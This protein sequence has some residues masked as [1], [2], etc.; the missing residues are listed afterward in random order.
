VI[1]DL[2][3]IASLT[4]ETTTGILKQALHNA[5][6]LDEVKLRISGLSPED[7]HQL[8]DE[9]MAL[10]AVAEA[11]AKQ[12][13]A[14][15][16]LPIVFKIGRGSLKNKIIIIPLVLILNFLL[17][18]ALSP[19]LV[20]GGI[21]LAYEGFE[22]I[23]D[24]FKPHTIASAEATMAQLGT[25]HMEA[26]KVA[27]AIKTDFILSFEIIVITLAL[28]EKTNFITQLMVLIVIAILST[29]FVYGIVALIIKLDDIGF[30]LQTKKDPLMPQ[31]G[32]C[33]VACMP[34]LIQIISI[35]GTVAM[36]LV[37]GGIINHETHLLH[38]AHAWISAIPLAS[39]VADIMVGI[40]AGAAV[41]L[42]KPLVQN[43]RFIF[44]SR[45]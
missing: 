39:L 24:R 12:D 4:N 44:Q 13:A 7:Q 21:F 2:A 18:W 27:S 37:G 10:R 22:S 16:E 38:K 29:V 28:L 9:L 31:L 30:Y 40:V 15:R 1:D 33:L 14:K 35:I 26:E 42:L 3:A 19:I 32:S 43:I 8:Y 23:I 34:Y 20:A 25:E 5:Q 17:P 45:S 41:V 6:S 11:K 36:L